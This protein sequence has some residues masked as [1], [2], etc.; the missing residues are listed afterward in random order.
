MCAC[1]CARASISHSIALSP[2]LPHQHLTDTWSWEHWVEDKQRES[3]DRR[4][5]EPAGVPS[6]GCSNKY[7]SPRAVARQGL[8][9]QPSLL[10]ACLGQRTSGA[11]TG[12]PPKGANLRPHDY[13]ALHGTE[14]PR[15]LHEHPTS[16]ATPAFLG[17]F[18]TRTLHSLSPKLPGSI[19]SFS[20]LW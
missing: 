18:I 2:S 7:A 12:P 4:C 13:Q 10:S 15:A 11:K 1:A 17:I 5:L 8:A 9:K 20:S 3:E 16:W 19:L 6:E 14:L